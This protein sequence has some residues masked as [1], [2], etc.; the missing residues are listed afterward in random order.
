MYNNESV[1]GNPYLVLVI[2]RHFR[3]SMLNT[4]KLKNT[5]LIALGVILL[6]LLVTMN[7]SQSMTMESRVHRDLL[8]EKARFLPQ[9]SIDVSQAMKLVTF[10]PAAPLVPPTPQ[11]PL[12][13][14]PPS[15]EALERLSGR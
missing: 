12:L 6:I 8:V 3:F 10:E 14:Y 15:V 1:V 4:M 5:V 2:L 11:P 9:N 13:L 7:R